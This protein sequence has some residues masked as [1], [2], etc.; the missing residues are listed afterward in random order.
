MAFRFIFLLS[1]SSSALY[2]QGFKLPRSTLAKRDL[3]SFTENL[4]FT[5]GNTDGFFV[6]IG[7][8]SNPADHP[9]LSAAFPES[10]AH[11]VLGL[12]PTSDSLI[13]NDLKDAFSPLDNIFVSNSSAPFATILFSGP[14]DAESSNGPEFAGLFSI[15]APVSLEAIFGSDADLNGLPNMTQIV[16]QPSIPLTHGTFTVS[17]I[18]VGGKSVLLSS[19]VSGAGAGT[20]V[21]LLSSRS[22]YTVV[23]IDIANAIYGSIQGSLYS[24]TSGLYT[25][26]CHTEITLTIVI[27]EITIPIDPSSV[28]IPL[29]GTSGSQCVG[30]YQADTERHITS[31]SYDI[32]FGTTFMENVY[33]LLG[34]G[35]APGQ[36]LSDP[37]M[38]LLPLTNLTEAHSYFAQYRGGN[39]QQSTAP[40]AQSTSF[41]TVTVTHTPTT[42]VLIGAPSSTPYSTSFASTSPSASTERISGNLDVQ[43]QVSDDNSSDNNGPTG[44]VVDQLK[45]CLPAIIVGA[46]VVGVFLIGG[47][48]YCLVS[49]NRRSGAKESAY[50]AIHYAESGDHS[51]SLYGH[52]EDP[53]KYS[54]PYTDK[55]P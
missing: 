19:S 37:I 53:S 16:N 36:S 23:P 3:S 54:D 17:E 31:P 34:Y 15:G 25:I 32:S 8:A 1:L 28:V 40:S 21:G 29:S 39:T 49:Q 12:G 5:S 41:T 13:V 4:I 33:I 10:N 38:R 6:E 42:T 24:A 46:I 11:G 2:S 51:R 18:A 27:G 20:A 52:D 50:K 43:D 35:T 22:P 47:I 26:P 14:D 55:M 44:S 48:T 7:V 9:G 30:S 45:H